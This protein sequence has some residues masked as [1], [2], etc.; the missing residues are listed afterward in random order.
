MAHV[1]DHVPKHSD[2]G[3]LQEVHAIWLDLSCSK[4]RPKN[5]LHERFQVLDE[6]YKQYLI[7]VKVILDPKI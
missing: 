5:K 6:K 1:E 2:Q 3:K 4:P 7:E